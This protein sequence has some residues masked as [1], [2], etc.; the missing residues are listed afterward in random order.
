L[1]GAA[2]RHGVRRLTLGASLP[3]AGGAAALLSGLAQLGKPGGVGGPSRG[4]KSSSSGSGGGGENNDGDDDD[5]DGGGGEDAPGS[6]GERAL[7]VLC[8]LMPERDG[9]L[10][11]LL[12]AALLHQDAAV[13]VPTKRLV[14][15]LQACVSTAPAAAS[16]NPLFLTLADEDDEQ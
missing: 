9:G 5:D 11:P 15:R 7:Q 10:G 3:D 6:R 14:R 2:L 1:D 13:R 16:L 12:G 4:G 8:N